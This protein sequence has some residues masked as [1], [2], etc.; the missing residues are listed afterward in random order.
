M[1][2]TAVY[3]N[4]F[5]IFHWLLTYFPLVSLTIVTRLITR[6]CSLSPEINVN[7]LPPRYQP[8]DSASFYSTITAP[9]LSYFQSPKSHF[10]LFKLLHL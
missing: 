5:C 4:Y 6:S 8:P 3:L 2:A 9:S 10:F 1:A 7:L